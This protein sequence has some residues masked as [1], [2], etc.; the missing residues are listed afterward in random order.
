MS[1]ISYE[2]GVFACSISECISLGCAVSY[3]CPGFMMYGGIY[4]I[5]GLL[6]ISLWP[7]YH[8]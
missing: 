6:N 1:Q 3:L 8:Y 7:D 2:R 5:S 4:R